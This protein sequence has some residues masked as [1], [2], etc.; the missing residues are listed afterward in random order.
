MPIPSAEIYNDAQ[1]LI[2]KEGGFMSVDDFNSISWLAQLRMMD[3]LS[4][5]VAGLVPP[6]PYNTQK[7]RDWISDFLVKYPAVVTNSIITKPT[8]YYLYENI[9]KLRAAVNDDC[10]DEEID[11]KKVYNVKVELLSNSKFY[12][13]CDTWI[14]ELKPSFNKIICKM[15]GNTI[16]FEP[17]DVGSVVLEYYRYPLKA[18]ITQ[19]IDPT[20]NEQV[21]ASGVNFEWGEYARPV[22]VWYIVQMFSLKVREN[23][24]F[25]QNA[26]LGKT[27][28]EQKI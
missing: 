1:F 21:I 24:M 17:S 27:T 18:T 8:N 26:A 13:R 6:E 15:V 28:R 3:W 7:N 4:G 16:E 9:Y 5:D 12:G 20:Y 14:E 22:L 11:S 19:T 23:A 2:N 10:S 25:S